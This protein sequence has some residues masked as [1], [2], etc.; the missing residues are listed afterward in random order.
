MT[1]AAAQQHK[2][3][4]RSHRF[5]SASPLSFNSRQHAR[6]S[7][8]KHAQ[9]RRLGQNLL[10]ARQPT[11]RNRGGQDEQRLVLGGDLLRARQMVEK[12]IGFVGE[13]MNPADANTVQVTLKGAGP[14]VPLYIAGARMR[15]NYPTSICVHGVALN[16]T[17]QSFDAQMDFGLMADGEAMPDVA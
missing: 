5:D 2:L 10:V 13:V 7:F 1:V 6:Q 8:G 16:I 15:C 17:V 11:E 4:G 3:F 12:D 9:C 14:E